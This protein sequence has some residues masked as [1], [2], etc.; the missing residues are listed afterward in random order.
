MHIALTKLAVK[1]FIEEL[2]YYGVAT[3][4][5]S[6]LYSLKTDVIKNFLTKV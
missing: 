3:A 6:I 4:F 2:N 5:F 1:D